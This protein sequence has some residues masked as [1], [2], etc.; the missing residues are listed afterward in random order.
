MQ[1]H[2]YSAN[3][4][5]ATRWQ[6]CHLE[7]PFVFEFPGNRLIFCQC[8]HKRRPA[9]NAVVQ[10]YYD[11]TMVWC[12]DG[13]GCNDPKAIAAKQRREFR[14]RSAGQRARWTKSSN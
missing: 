6:D 10:S 11:C 1:M 9:K 3:M 4:Q 7:P 13:K 2:I 8:C 12:A 14:N 5:P